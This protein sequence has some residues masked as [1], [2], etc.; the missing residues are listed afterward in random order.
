[1]AGDGGGKAPQLANAVSGAENAARLLTTAFP[2][3]A[4]VEVSMEQCEMN[5]QPGAIFRD[6][7]G[8]VQMIRSVINPQKLAH[9]GPVADG[10][11]LM[12]EFNATRRPGNAG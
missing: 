9:M 2:W 6:R 1:M 7:D 10:W 11:S 4:R 5:G 12:R 8:R 3:L